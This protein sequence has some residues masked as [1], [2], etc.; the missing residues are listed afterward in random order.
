[1]SSAL[2][3][4]PPLSPE[5]VTRVVEVGSPLITPD[6]TILYTATRWE[7]G[8]QVTDLSEVSPEGAPRVLVT[9]Q[10]ETPALS[11]DGQSLAYIGAV[12]GER[13]LVLC[14]RTTGEPRLLTRFAG[15]PRAPVWSPDGGRLLVEVLSPPIPPTA[16]RVRMRLRYDL[17]GLGDLDDRR[18]NVWVVDAV[19]GAAS[20]LGDPAWHHFYPSWAPDGRRVVC[21]TTRR[22]DWD[23]EWVW[24]VY[25]VD[26]DR[27]TWTRLTASDGVARM[28]VVTRDGRYVA[29][30]HNHD[31]TTSST[32][33]YH[34]CLVAVDGSEPPRC[35]SHAWDRGAV[36]GMVPG[37]MGGAPVEWTSGRFLWTALHEGR[38]VV[39]MTDIEGRTEIVLS[40]VASV[41]LAADGHTGA[42]LGFFEDRPPEVCRVDVAAR[43]ATPVSDSNPWLAERRPIPRPYAVVM[44]TEHGPVS[45]W[46]WEPSGAR[47]HP[48]VI[49][50]HGGPHGA[51]GP[52]FPPLYQ[53]LPAAQGF[54][55][56]APNFRG[57]GGFGQA[58]ADL[59]RENWGR[60]EGE[61]VAAL[62]S[63]LVANGVAD[64]SRVGV[65]GGSYGGFLTNWMVTHYPDLAQA[66]VSMSTIADLATLALTGDHWESAQTDFGG[67]PWEI[68][69]YYREHSPIT[70]ADRITTPL[71]ILHG[72]EDRTCPPFE[73]EQLFVA[74]RWQKKPVMWV[75]YPG[76]AHGYQLRGRL[77]TRIDVARRV[78][79]WFLTHLGQSNASDTSKGG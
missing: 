25:V 43:T 73:A 65:Y 58:F 76:E 71:L 66:A 53:I 45:S 26:L 68:P 60:H 5:D 55:V 78:L 14:P 44:S 52:Y 29:Y 48:T 36:Q 19:T 64:P 61:D 15:A 12:Q 24:D 4:R 20:P 32:T 6:G 28:P 23:L 10:V 70:Y 22:P 40:D 75:E 17:N 38:Q 3:F 50:L 56:A 67:P 41:A 1:M 2:E 39:A 7:K 42:G 54:V 13:G 62:V 79:D 27:R 18:W 31:T 16:P 51:V 69:A 30:F 11:P 9:G 74:L 8:R 63:H 35:L 77:E 47:P 49:F 37:R 57:S 33:D 21:V 34:L 72:S 59:C 46:V